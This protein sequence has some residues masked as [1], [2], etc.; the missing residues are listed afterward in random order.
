MRGSR[1]GTTGQFQSFLTREKVRPKPRPLGTYTQ[2]RV[3]GRFGLPVQ[4]I[5]I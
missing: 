2:N 1:S 4:S 3:N 5:D